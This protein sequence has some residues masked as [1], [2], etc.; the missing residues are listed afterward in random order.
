[1]KNIDC[2]NTFGFKAAWLR[3]F[4]RLRADFW[5]QDADCVNKKQDSFLRFLRDANIVVGSKK[6]DRAKLTLSPF[7]EFILQSDC[8]SP[9]IWGLIVCELVY[10]PLFNWYVGNVE[11]GAVYQPDHLKLLIASALEN[12][13]KGLKNRNVFDSIKTIM[14][15]T[16]IGEILGLGVCICDQKKTTAGIQ[17]KLKSLERGSWTTPDPLVIL[18]SLYKFAEAGQGGYYDFSLGSLMQEGVERD[19]VSPAQV[20]GIDRDTMEGLVKGLSVNHPDFVSGSFS[21]GLDNIRLNPEKRSADV[22]ALFH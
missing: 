18:Y 20:F 10:S 17:R 13:N 21:L 2:Y 16:P 7:G 14:T 5:T 22:L 8:S 1:M 19:G 15:E 9:S 12:D 11:R 6:T 4:A 3:N